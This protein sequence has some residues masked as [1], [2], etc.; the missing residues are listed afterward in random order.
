VR[1]RAAFGLSL[2]ALRYA[3]EMLRGLRA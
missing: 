2:A 3:G 1:T